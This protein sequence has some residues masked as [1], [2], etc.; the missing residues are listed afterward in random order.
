[1][2]KTKE[3][4]LKE[5]ATAVVTMDEAEAVALA[6]QVIELG[7][8]VQEALLEGLA[9]GMDIVGRKYESGDYFIPQ[10]LVCS[11]VMNAAVEI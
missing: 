5:L 7:I 8:D 10:M 6:N 2:M 3:Q 4:L 1:M 9:K 11:D